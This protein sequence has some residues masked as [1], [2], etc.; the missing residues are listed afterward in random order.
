[1]MAWTAGTDK[2]YLPPSQLL[3]YDWSKFVPG[4]PTTNCVWPFGV[5]SAS[6]CA[7]AGFTCTPTS[8]DFAVFSVTASAMCSNQ[9]SDGDFSEWWISGPTGAIVSISPQLKF[10]CK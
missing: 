2:K 9:K 4:K 6:V 10:V 8:K 3:N 1:M 7:P 5:K